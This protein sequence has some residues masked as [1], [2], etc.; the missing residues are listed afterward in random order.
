MTVRHIFFTPI[1]TSIRLTVF[2]SCDNQIVV[3]AFLA[4]FDIDFAC[5]HK[6]VQFSTGPHAKYT[7]WKYVVLTLIPLLTAR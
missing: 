5:T 4:W 3:H 1:I 2:I 6:K 7:H